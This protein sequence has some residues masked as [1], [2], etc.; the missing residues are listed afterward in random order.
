[1]K[2]Q[3]ILLEI[4]DDVI[5]IRDK[6]SWAKTPRILLVWP[7]KGQVG[8]RPLDLTLLRRH[9][10][11]LGAELGLVTR[12]AEIY[13][14]ARRMGLPVFSKPG[15][16]QRKNWPL[17]VSF[18][19]ERR[20]PR[21]DL[22]AI[23]A[24]LP[25]SDLFADFG[26]S[27]VARLLIF[28][29]GVLAV[30]LVP[31]FFIHSAEIRLTPPSRS[32]RVEIAV[33]AEPN[34]QQVSLAGVLPSRLRTFEFELSDS[35]PASGQMVVPSAAAEGTVRFINLSAPAVSVPVGTV[36][37]T[38][39]NPPVRFATLEAAD[40]SLGRGSLAYVRVR[41]LTPGAAGNVSAGSI[42]AFEGPLG[43]SLGVTNLF[44]MQGGA[45]L[46]TAAP[47][48]A[49]R[50]ALHQRLLDNV[51]DQAKARLAEQFA[52]GDV[53]FPSSFG[54]TRL[55]T[56]TYSP[57]PGEAGGK[58]KLTL[59]AE[60]QVHYAAA[61]DLAQLAESVLD[62]SLTA[63]DA[64]D[65]A[66]LKIVSISPLFGGA[67]GLTRWR[68]RATRTVRA[69]ID[70]AQVI[71]IARGQTARRAGSLLRES[72]GLDSDPTISIQPFFWP[73]LPTLPFRIKV[74]E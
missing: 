2:T 23:R 59:R 60:F 33:S 51:I 65:E 57:G 15:H 13:A 16:A 44:A 20:A 37:L 61:A 25:E 9:A 39:S 10:T 50:L 31:M 14:A 22:R 63:E 73:W 21:L 19:P 1:M 11:S 58:L 74:M 35:I 27:I 36:V 28:S 24:E 47:T 64:P 43:L 7:S 70:S 54:F 30:L 32:Q 4:H 56:E 12:D 71:S 42:A 72:L 52:P 48:D 40:V 49:D 8:V 17:H 67:D 5:S 69:H 41:A 3:L 68:I 6:M 29:I 34:A 55:L 38:L 53:V 66:S 18:H 45:D 26:Q 46:T 62:T